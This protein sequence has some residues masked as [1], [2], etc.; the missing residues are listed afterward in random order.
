M[1][2]LRWQ[3]QIADEV[4]HI[5]KAKKQDLNLDPKKHLQK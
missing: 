1:G 4:P 3:L 5:H 2:L